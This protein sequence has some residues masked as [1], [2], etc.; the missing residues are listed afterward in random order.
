M[1]G[2]TTAAAAAAA[3]FR[4]PKKVVTTA[5]ANY[6][7]ASA[8]AATACSP[9][10]FASAQPQEPQPPAAILTDAWPN[11][12]AIFEFRDR[13]KLVSRQ[14]RVSVREGT[15]LVRCQPVSLSQGSTPDL[16][17]AQRTAAHHLLCGLQHCRG[18]HSRLRRG[19]ARGGR[20]ARSG[21]EAAATIATAYRATIADTWPDTAAIFEFRDRSELVSPVDAS[22]AATATSTRQRRLRWRMVE[23]QCA[24]RANV[25]ANGG[26]G[27]PRPRMPPSAA[28]PRRR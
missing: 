6:S 3:F 7:P 14:R 25:G 10:A 22:T 13:S 21:R 26:S 4:T 28:L 8:A 17:P 15:V 24:V 19:N 9:T 23:L 18:L 27:R 11:T 2:R 20:V 1:S 5:A 12:A 16:K